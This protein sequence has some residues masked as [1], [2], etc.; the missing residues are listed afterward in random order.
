M[1]PGA[2]A[3][4]G[5]IDANSNR[6]PLA[7]EEAGGTAVGAKDPPEL[8]HVV[9]ADRRYIFRRN[10]ARE[11]LRKRIVSGFPFK[12]RHPERPLKLAI[13]AENLGD[14]HLICVEDNGI[15]IEGEDAGRIFDIFYSTSPQ[16][17]SGSGVG[18]AIAKKVVEVH[19]GRI[20][21]E[22]RRGEGSR[23][24]FTLS[25]NPQGK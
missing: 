13:N 1:C 18:L 9:P 20:W 5:P 7:V 6:C 16:K 3:R 23:F 24:Y 22:S 14:A 25:K 21:V 2:R 11:I 8:V 19:R 17:D 15:G 12:H 10:Q 4:K